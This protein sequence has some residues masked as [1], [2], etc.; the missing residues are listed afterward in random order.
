MERLRF[1]SGDGGATDPDVRAPPQTRTL[2]KRAE[3]KSR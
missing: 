3:G 2:K 1:A